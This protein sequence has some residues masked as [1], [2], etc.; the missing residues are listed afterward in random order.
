MTATMPATPTKDQRIAHLFLTG[1]SLDLISE[2]GTAGGWN[3]SDVRR[4]AEQN[5]WTLD[6]SG[7]IPRADRDRFA[8]EV[9]RAVAAP[10]PAPRPAAP[11]PQPT[12]PAPVLA[13]PRWAAALIEGRKHPVPRIKRLADRLHAQLE[14]LAQA[15]DAADEERKIRERLVELEA[16]RETLRAQLRKTPPAKT[17]PAKAAPPPQPEPGEQKPIE[18]GTW[19]GFLMESQRG[20][21]HCPDCTAAKDQVMAARAAKRGGPA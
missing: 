14:E 16:E 13:L 8:A 11:A 20:L 3:R 7:R 2:R 19:G 4:V 5:G 6:S 21:Q 10:K 9:D 12:V 17:P 15:M 18:H 1:Y